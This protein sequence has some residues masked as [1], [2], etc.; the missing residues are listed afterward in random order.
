MPAMKEL[1]TTST[2][3]HKIYSMETDG[4]TSVV[5]RCLSGFTLINWIANTN[6]EYGTDWLAGFTNEKYKQ[7]AYTLTKD[8]F[9]LYKWDGSNDW[10]LIAYINGDFTISSAKATQLCNTYKY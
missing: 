4:H 7:Y 8:L 3:M 5:V 1:A 6:G 2:G 10:N 9:G